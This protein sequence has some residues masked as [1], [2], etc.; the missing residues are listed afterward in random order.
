MFILYKNTI[1]NF[2]TLHLR[3]HENIKYAQ[4]LAHS[5]C[6][7]P[8]SIEFRQKGQTVYHPKMKVIATL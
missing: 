1:Q 6:T 2:I 4:N 3:L 5:N 8:R 7:R